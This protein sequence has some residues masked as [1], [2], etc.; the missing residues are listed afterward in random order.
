M[1]GSAQLSSAGLGFSPILQCGPGEQ[2]LCAAN[3]SIQKILWQLEL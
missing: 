1:V 3:E 2:V